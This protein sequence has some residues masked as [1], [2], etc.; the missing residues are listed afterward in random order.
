MDNYESEVKRY[1]KMIDMVFNG[2]RMPISIS[3]M[4]NIDNNKLIL[5]ILEKQSNKL[6]VNVNTMD[7]INN[8]ELITPD[9]FLKTFYE[10]I[11]EAC[12]NNDSIQMCFSQFGDDL[13]YGDIYNLI[14][15]LPEMIICASDEIDGILIIFRQSQ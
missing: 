4:F 15:K 6:I 13:S 5:K 7:L 2:Y 10:A 1:C 12:E 14:E 8:H 11:K 9:M 3:P